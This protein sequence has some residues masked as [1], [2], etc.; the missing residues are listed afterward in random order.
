MVRL[1]AVAVLERPPARRDYGLTGPDSRRAVDARPRRRP[2][3]PA[4]DR[5]AAAA[6]ADSAPRRPRGARRRAVAG[7]AR[8]H[9]RAGLLQ[10]R[11]VVGDPGLR[12]VRHAVR[13][14]SPTPAGTSAG[15]ARPSG[16]AGPT[17]P[18]TTWRRSCCCASRRC[19]AGRTSATTPTRSSS[20]AT[21][22]C[23]SP[24]RS[25]GARVLPNLFNLVNGPKM[26]WRMARHASGSIDDEAR[27]FV[28]EDEL[29][30]RRVGGAGVPRRARWRGRLVARDRLDRAVAVHRP[31]V[32]L[33]RVAAVVLRH[34]P[35]RRAPRG[36][37]R[38][39]PEHA[40]GVHEPGAAVPV[41]EHELPP[42][43]PPVPDGAVPRPA[44]AARRGR[45]PPPPPE[46]VG[47]STPTARSSTPCA[48]SATT[49]TGRSPAGS[50][51]TDR[52]RARTSTRP[53]GTSPTTTPPASIDLGPA[54]CS[55]RAS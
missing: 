33:R 50:C 11:L 30:P 48:T 52:P 15:T 4:A 5:P 53:P 8:R 25:G 29:A 14:S 37:P 27:D 21:R 40:H 9:R 31:A 44:G 16:R 35:A 1:A 38:P 26:L 54:T 28:P 46:H 22:R 42:R 6:G 19:G 39:P 23:C 43:A 7:A 12:R 32:V 13:R 20:G 55:A 45:H 34:H 49:P 17:T 18:S 24:D 2:V 41:P 36:R 10:P 51:P 47:R 3:V